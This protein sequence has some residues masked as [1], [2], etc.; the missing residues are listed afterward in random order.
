MERLVAATS[1]YRPWHVRCRDGG[2]DGQ[3]VA[4]CRKH[5]GNASCV[6]VPLAVLC[7]S[8]LIVGRR[9]RALF[10]MSRLPVPGAHR[11]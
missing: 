10:I 11:P 6:H 4:R 7:L 5:V 1:W 9:S 2:W 3:V 8:V